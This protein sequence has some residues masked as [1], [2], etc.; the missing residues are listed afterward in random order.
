M[1]TMYSILLIAGSVA[2]LSFKYELDEEKRRKKLEELAEVEKRTEKNKNMW[3]EY[4]EEK[5]LK[6][7]MEEI[8]EWR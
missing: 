4:F 6:I 3:N 8:E 5:S 7:P 1:I 2:L